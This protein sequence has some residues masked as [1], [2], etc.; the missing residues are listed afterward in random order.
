MQFRHVEGGHRK[1]PSRQERLER[2][3]LAPHPAHR[4]GGNA[5]GMCTQ[6]GNV[7]EIGDTVAKTEDV[8]LVLLREMTNFIKSRDFVAAIRWERYALAHE[9]DS[10]RQGPWGVGSQLSTAG[11]RRRHRLSRPGRSHVQRF[12]IL[13]LWLKARAKLHP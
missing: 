5:F 7:I 1:R 4:S 13:I 12:Q 11:L 6:S 9:E 2:S 8:H 3:E 10:H